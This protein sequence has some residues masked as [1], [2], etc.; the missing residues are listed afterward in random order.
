MPD[1]S[2]EGIDWI[3]VRERTKN[4]GFGKIYRENNKALKALGLSYGSQVIV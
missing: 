4:F 3:R 1:F 2:I